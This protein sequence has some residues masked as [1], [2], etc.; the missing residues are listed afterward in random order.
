M[1]PLPTTL[2]E[3]ALWARY[4]FLKEHTIKFL[5]VATPVGNNMVFN[6][7]S[8]LIENISAFPNTAI[9]GFILVLLDHIWHLGHH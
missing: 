8:T 1:N 9:C 4:E 7:E 5:S 3:P 2:H 6:L